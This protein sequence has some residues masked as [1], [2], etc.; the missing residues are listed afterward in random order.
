MRTTVGRSGSAR[1]HA[2]PGGNVFGWNDRSTPRRSR[3]LDAMVAAGAKLSRYRR[4]LHLGPGKSGW[5]IGNHQGAWIRA[6][7]TEIG[8][9]PVATKVGVGVEPE[10]RRGSRAPYI[11]QAVE[12]S[13]PGLQTDTWTCTRSHAMIP[14]RRPEERRGLTVNWYAAGQGEGDRGVRIRADRLARLSR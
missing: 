6:A 2:R 7:A 14:R 5:G 13:L 12:G 9:F 1:I 4:L 3:V 11:L 8:S 10:P